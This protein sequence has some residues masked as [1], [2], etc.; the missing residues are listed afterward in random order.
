MKTVK[1][2]SNLA[3]LLKAYDVPVKTIGMVE[4][5]YSGILHEAVKEQVKEKQD[6]QESKTKKPSIADLAKNARLIK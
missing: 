4:E 2:P 1:M 6:K 3:E 5:Y